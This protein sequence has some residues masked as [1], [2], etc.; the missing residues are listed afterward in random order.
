VPWGP[1]GLAAVEA[2]KDLKPS[3]SPRA[4]ELVSAAAA[5][6]SSAQHLHHALDG[7][8]ALFQ[9]HRHPLRGV[10]PE[11]APASCGSASM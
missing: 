11:E 4:Y 6:R 10:H 7:P 9:A 2:G 1:D 5:T 3:F 8:A